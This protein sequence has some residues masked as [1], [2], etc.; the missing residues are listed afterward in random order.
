MTNTWQDI[1][2]ANVVLCMGDN[3]AEAHPCG[4]KWVIEAKIEN[5]AKLVA[6][7]PRFT[8]TASVAD[9]YAPIRPGTDIA[10]LS[11]VIHFLLGKGAIQHDY[12][13]AY[14]NAS[15]IV[16]EGFGFEDG[17][18][19]GYDERARSYD[20][21]SWDY[22][23]DEQGYARIDDTWQHP[24]CVINLLRKHVD[25]YTP[26][27]VSRICGTPPDKYLE[28]CEL[29]A[30]TAAP[31]KALTSLFALG[32]T[33]HSVGAQNIR[34]MA[35]VQL[36]LGNIGVAGGGM[37][38]LRGHS[39]IQGLT[40]VGLL[41][42][43]MPGYL[44]LPKDGEA[45]FEQYM[46]TRQFKPL[47][48]GQASYWQNYRKFFV[49]FQKAIYGDAARAD[50]GWAYDWLPKLDNDG[51]DILRAFEMMVNGEVNGYVCQ[52]FNPLQAF[53]DRGKIRRA[54]RRLKFLVTMD[55]LDT[56]TSRFWQDFGPQ[57]P[58]D[59]ATIQTEVFQLPTTCF[60]EENGSLVNSARWLQWHWKAADGPGD[61]RSDIWI[62]SGIFHRMR[63]MYRKE[64]GAFPDPILNLAWNYTNPASPNPEELAKDMNG[65]ALADL[66]D[67]TGAVT[68]RAGQLLDSY[69]QL[70][71]DGTTS[72]G[73]WI[74]S[75]CYTEQGN[76]MARRDATDPREQG[77]APNWAWAWPANRRILYNRASADVAGNPWNPARPIIQWN[78]SRWVGIDVPDYAPTTKPSDAVGPFIMNAEGVGRL[79]ARDQMV[80]GPFPE[81][82]E[83]FESPVPNVLHAKVQ[84][85]PVAR[86]FANDRAAFG[87][88]QDFPYVAT[89]YRLTEHFHFWT[90][91]AL[92]NAI[93]QPEEFIEI[94]EVLAKEKGI[95]QGGWVRVSS[96]RG[97]VVCKAYV[98]KR[99][100]PM[101]VDGKPTHVIGV[102]IHWGFTGQA[103]KGY[104][105]NT[106]T[107]SVGDANTETPEYKAFL[108][109]VEKTSAPAP[110]RAADV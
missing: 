98:T 93:L 21:S 16:K 36:L 2:N 20:K 67:E 73:C 83:P 71:D 22:E 56:E 81:H 4:F 46:A 7:D 24:R 95:E 32:W 58:S 1:K 12:V 53:P 65:R 108:V 62:M 33:Q 88:A 107:P 38:A 41:S 47:R 26:E 55:P 18:F 52:G 15:L 43:Q 90:K 85:N 42:A 100:R 63:E 91:H 106:L 57:N 5:N 66:K 87:T 80:E 25:R 92:I 28:I 64:G 31:D 76:Q 40:D 103:R 27:M 96:K 60:A 104:G 6:V 79:F 11:G 77:I 44:M 3:A 13:R 17:L 109:N 54:L 69:A 89:T 9:L 68:L 10:F 102:P 97:V 61:A 39:N 30:T 45:T 84:S 37:N 19:T 86:V 105:A 101:T 48:P 78:G 75:G 110:E 8:R 94:G 99:I 59:P 34:T 49:S 35:M 14:T 74:F 72:S 50:N 70:R 23:L 29:I 51:Y 82:Y